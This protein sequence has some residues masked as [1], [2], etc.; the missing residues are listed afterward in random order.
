MASEST[1]LK[2]PTKLNA[3]GIFSLALMGMGFSVTTPAMSSIVAQFASTGANVSLLSQ[4]YAF[5]MVPCVLIAG[6][7]VGNKVRYKWVAF[8]GTLM[9]TIFGFLPAVLPNP[10][11]TT[12]IVCRALFGVGIGI[13]NPVGKGLILAIYGGNRQATFM[14]LYTTFTNLGGIIFQQAGGWLAGADAAMGWKLHY[15]GYLICIIGVIGSLFLPDPP[16]TAKTV[17]KD[18]A[19]AHGKLGIACF[20]VGIFIL[21]V[22]L[23]NQPVFMGA[24]IF[25]RNILT[26]GGSATAASSAPI[27]AAQAMTLYTIVGMV[28][29]A[30][31]GLIFMAIGRWVAPLGMF[32]GALGAFFISLAGGEGGQ[33]WMVFAGTCTLGVG[34]AFI[35]PAAFQIV[36]IHTSKI[37]V[38]L[39]TAIT[40]ALMNCATFLSSYWLQALAGG[41]AAAAMSVSTL[42]HSAFIGIFIYLVMGIILVVFNPFKK[43]GAAA[44]AEAK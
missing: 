13:M 40:I 2:D 39:A 20:I 38:G 34:F 29:G 23:V 1:G 9:M 25:V 21:F 35:L 43:R 8:F 19:E 32:C 11:F 31:Y 15:F 41:N 28:I 26:A 3:I 30:V 33:L 22:N 10:D 4:A 18:S 12:L 14:G 42:T 27:I 37:R 5:T 6:I 17:S 16:V 36:G 7:L 24:S 44:K